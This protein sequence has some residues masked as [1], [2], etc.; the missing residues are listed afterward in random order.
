MDVK[1][2]SMYQCQYCGRNYENKQDAISCEDAY[3]IIKTYEELLKPWKWYKI[4]R[5]DKIEF[6]FVDKVEFYYSCVKSAPCI[7]LTVSLFEY[8]ANCYYDVPSPYRIIEILTPNEAYSKYGLIPKHCRNMYHEA[9]LFGTMP[10][11]VAK[12]LD[13]I[14]KDS[15]KK[16]IEDLLEHY[17]KEELA[18]LLTEEY[19]PIYRNLSFVKSVEE[20]ELITKRPNTIEERIV[21]INGNLNPLTAMLGDMDKIIDEMKDDAPDIRNLIY[22]KEKEL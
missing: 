1:T 22:G 7:N 13:N 8:G 20:N 11:S 12:I 4:K 17:S 6:I 21:G 5:K 10:M 15:K 19:N 2:I 3:K 16:S 9:T 18:K 14:V